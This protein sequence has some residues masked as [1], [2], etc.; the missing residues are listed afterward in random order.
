M[1]TYLMTSLLFVVLLCVNS[2][3]SDKK[4]SVDAGSDDH[5]F[6]A[7]DD[8]TSTSSSTIDDTDSENLL[9]YGEPCSSAFGQKTCKNGYCALNEHDNC[10]VCK[11]FDKL[12][13]PCT[14]FCNTGSDVTSSICDQNICKELPTKENETCIQEQ[15]GFDLYCDMSDPKNPI[16]KQVTYNQKEGEECDDSKNCQGEQIDLICTYT[17]TGTGLCKKTYFP[18]EGEPC[19]QESYPGCNGYC[20][21]TSTTALSGICSS[22]APKL[23]DPCPLTQIGFGLEICGINLVC[24]YATFRCIEPKQ[25]GESCQ[26]EYHGMECKSLKC[27]YQSKKCAERDPTELVC[28]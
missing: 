12:G 16:C 3:K 2:C 8:F 4:E 7:M 13:D 25:D 15:C 19:D 28:E 14:D 6:M 9:E 20:I 10:G 24:D 26:T 1:K 11:P 21:R 22:V 5:D 17:Y 27:D 23:G 18:K